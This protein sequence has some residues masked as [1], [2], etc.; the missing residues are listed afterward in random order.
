V[1]IDLVLYPGFSGGPL[2]TASGA[3]AGLVSS[4]LARNL[5]LAIPST[6]VA[7]VVDELVA[8]GR[9]SRGYLGVGLQPVALPEAL[10]RLT[11]GSAGYGLM[12][13]SLEAD[14]P[15]ARAGVML[16]DILVAVDGAALREPDDVQAALAG[17]R[18]GTSVRA[19]LIR[20][21]AALEVAVTLGERPARRR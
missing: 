20:G 5:E 2:V 9:V 16:G 11:S 13:V 12:V 17:R 10:R 14:G 6:T 4:G 15:A 19:A 18:P 21:G 8:T 3:V 1:R 7:R